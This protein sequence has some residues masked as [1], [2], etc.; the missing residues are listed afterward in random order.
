LGVKIWK[1]NDDALSIYEANHTDDSGRKP[2]KAANDAQTYEA[3]CF[4]LFFQKAALL[5]LP[6]P[7][8]APLPDESGQAIKEKDGRQLYQ[9]K[10]QLFFYPGIS[11]FYILFN[12]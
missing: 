6:H 5:S 1:E 4:I 2:A 7:P 12:N 3:S 10:E 9:M 8:S 11:Y